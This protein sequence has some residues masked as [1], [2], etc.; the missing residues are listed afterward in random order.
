MVLENDYLRAAVTA[1][2]AE[3]N[4]LRRRSDQMEYLWNADPAYWAKTS[5]VLFPVVGALKD[6]TYLYQDQP[7]RLPRHGFARDLVFHEEQVSATAGEFTLTDTEETR[8]VYPFAFQLKLR[9]A[10]AGTKLTCTYEV[11]NPDQQHPLL[12]SIGGHPAFATPTTGDAGYGDYY[13]EFP[14]DEV[15]Y[16][17][18]VVGNLVGDSISVIPLEDH[19][20]PLS[21]AL[22]Y[23]DALVL[24]TLNS[25]Q[26][27]LRNKFNASGLR[28]SRE[29]FP[30]FGIWAARDADFVCLEPW[31][32]IA[33]GVAHNQRLEEKEGIQRLAAG[34]TWTATWAVE[35]F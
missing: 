6:D 2:G 24:K 35:C 30:Y 26:I 28:F 7:Y 31:Y 13:L 19:R 32:G 18:R 23:A 9:Y 22:F 4:S 29:H 34:E 17:H 21:H 25:Q 11:S 20:L 14:D 12:F 15:L 5:P 16:C 3:L 33:D 10:L 1:K 27:S 8:N